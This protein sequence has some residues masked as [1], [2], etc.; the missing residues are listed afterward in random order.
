M[1]KE[2]I[3][4]RVYTPEVGSMPSHFMICTP[5]ELHELRFFGLHGLYA[6]TASLLNHKQIEHRKWLPN[7]CKELLHH[8]FMQT[9]S[10]HG[11]FQ[12]GVPFFVVSEG[13]YKLRPD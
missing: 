5:N 10:F 13:C 9:S 4:A 3:V 7:L 1:H 6:L 11:L 12:T 2:M 8:R